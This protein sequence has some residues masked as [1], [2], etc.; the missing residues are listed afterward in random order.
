MSRQQEQNRLRRTNYGIELEQTTLRDD[1]PLPS[2][3][4]MDRLRNVDSD[5]PK[6]VMEYAVR[7][8]NAR[9]DFNKSRIDITRS[10]QNKTTAVKIVFIVAILIIVL[11]A[12]GLS[13]SLIAQGHVVYGSIFAGA[14]IVALIV[15][16]SKIKLQ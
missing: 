3:S 4:E 16:V 2:A 8:Q 9:I 10:E 11:A 5:L 15:A 13:Y 7:E 12:F 14:D 6:F 1:Y